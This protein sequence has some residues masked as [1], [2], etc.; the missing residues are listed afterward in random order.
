MSIP[1]ICGFGLLAAVLATATLTGQQPL[2]EQYLQSGKLDE[3]ERALQQHLVSNPDDDQA[4]FGLGTLQFMQAVEQLA[5][6]W[7]RFGNTSELRQIPLFRLPVPD[8]PNPEQVDYEMVRQVFENMTEHLD[9]ADRTLAQVKSRKVKLPLRLFTF[10]LDIN[11]D[12]KRDQN[13]DLSQIYRMYFGNNLAGAP[14][15]PREQLVV[16][17]DY[18]DV[19][20]LRG[21]THLLRAMLEFGLAYDHEPLW[22]VAGHLVFERAK[23]KHA[24]QQEEQDAFRANQ[25]RNQPRYWSPNWISDVVA[26]IHNTSF[27]IRE[28]A[29]LKRAHAHLKEMIGLSREMWKSVLAETDND[30]EW[31]PSPKQE[32]AVSPVRVGKEMIAT[33]HDFLREMELLLDGELLIPFWRGTNPR[34][35]VNLKRVFFEPRDLDV[36]MW[37]QGTGAMPYVEMG[38]VSSERTWGQFQRVFRG[39]FFG[40]A[41]WFN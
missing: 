37:V 41:L 17:F 27:K 33:W 36:I 28:P 15:Q 21:Y 31:I 18:S 26:A 34:R 10:H 23:L 29:R 13:E 4:R 11:R 22:D 25:R 32:S 35:G 30:R 8:N 14:G 24:F 3:G 16:A 40:F 39:E 6:D 5:Q 9:R 2:V 19:L 7:H 1:K 12:G 20:W 38:D